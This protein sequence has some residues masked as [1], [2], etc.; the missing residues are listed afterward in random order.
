M[1]IRIEDMSKT[2]KH[3]KDADLQLRTALAGAE[4]SVRQLKREIE[5]MREA[6]HIAKQHLAYAISLH[7]SGEGTI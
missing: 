1:R 4:E 5:E 6:T 2:I 7:D 3:L